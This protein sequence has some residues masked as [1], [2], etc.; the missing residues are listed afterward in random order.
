MR[1]D[2]NEISA[3]KRGSVARFLTSRDAS[4]G[5]KNIAG[6]GILG[7]LVALAFA[8]KDGLGNDLID[9]IIPTVEG[10]TSTISNTSGQGIHSSHGNHVSSG[11]SGTGSGDGGGDGG[12][13]GG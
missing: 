10:H 12:D 6:T 7:S 2:E 11:D 3:P 1:K 4:I 8:E 5:T 13:G 9:Q